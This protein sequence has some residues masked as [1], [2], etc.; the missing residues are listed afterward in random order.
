MV[1]SGEDG[2]SGRS[3]LDSGRAWASLPSREEEGK[4]AADLWRDGCVCDGDDISGSDSLS[5]SLGAEEG[6]DS[7]GAE[8]VF[9][10]MAECVPPISSSSPKLKYWSICAI[11]SSRGHS[12]LRKLRRK[13]M[14][15]LLNPSCAR[16][17]CKSVKEESSL[18]MTCITGVS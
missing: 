5:L 7:N 8:C 14:L 4:K 11:V 2:T 15:P 16:D 13:R 6:I 1:W 12:V 17:F 3:T 9:G 18:P 10:A